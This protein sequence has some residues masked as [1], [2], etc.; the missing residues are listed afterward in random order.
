MRPQG[1]A[2]DD[3]AALVRRHP[4]RW[5]FDL[6]G[7][8][9]FLSEARQN[10]AI[11]FFIA[12]VEDHERRAPALV[13]RIFYKD[14]SLVWRVAS[15]MIAQDD[16][17]WIGKGDVET[18]ERGG[19]EWQ[20]SLEHTTDLPFELQH[21][22]E[23]CNRATP[24]VREDEAVLWD[25]L[26]NAPMGRV[27]PYADF[28]RPRARDRHLA[29]RGGRPIAR[30]T[31][32][33]DPSSLR[34][35]KGF[36]PDFSAVLSETASRSVT[37][38]GDLRRTR[39]ASENRRI[40]YLFFEGPEHVWLAPP[41]TLRTETSSYGVRTA[42][43]NA[44]DDIF[45]PG[46]EYHYVDETSGELISQIPSGFAGAQSEHDDGRACAKPWLDALPVVQAY[47]RRLR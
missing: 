14:I 44:P 29:P 19:Y 42:S 28:V 23:I 24:K 33:G 6:F 43:V 22:L 32:P 8:R 34:F 27:Q 13:P 37:Y 25:V 26:R 21:A 9:I 10:P 30:F 16:E 1:E 36:A 4:P 2:K 41:Q 20:E 5:E 18:I 17:F 15:H 46:F 3:P 12:Y 11:R 31:R 47:R 35:V 38:G 40:Q 45:L 7:R 39:F